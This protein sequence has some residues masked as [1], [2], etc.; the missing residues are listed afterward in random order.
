MEINKPIIVIGT[1]RCGSTIFVEALG[2][3]SSLAWPSNVLYRYPKLPVLNKQLMGLINSP[4][5]E[6]RIRSRVAPGEVYP[7]W[8][9]LYPPFREGNDDSVTGIT[10]EIKEKTRRAFSQFLNKKRNRLLLKI[11][12]WPR[13]KMLQRF[14]PD[15][16]IIHMYRDGRAVMHSN[17]K[18]PFWTGWNGPENWSWGPLSEKYDAQYKQY[19]ESKTALAAIQW[20]ILMDR[21][22]EA[23]NEIVHPENYLEV[24]YEEMCENQEAFFKKICAFCDLSYDASFQKKIEGYT[25]KNTNH[26]W[27][28]ALNE[29]DQ[30]MIKEILKDHLQEW[31]YS[32]NEEDVI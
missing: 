20:N 18:V 5:L 9:R 32:L 13:V 14:F 24:S 31:N 7:F 19:N 21:F 29:E 22:K 26:K 27:K 17:L 10:E 30:K 28:E 2:W 6:N 3:H 25:F 1:G 15:A 8:D 4:G 23:R 16:K 12:G 11:T